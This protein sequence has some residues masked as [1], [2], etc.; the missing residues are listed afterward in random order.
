MDTRV[1]TMMTSHFIHIMTMLI[2]N[3]I[4]VITMIGIPE[5]RNRKTATRNPHLERH[6]SKPETQLPTHPV[7]NYQSLAEGST[8]QRVLTD[9]D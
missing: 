2:G 7:S 8:L 9:I 5:T 4:C 3:S 1:I 6:K